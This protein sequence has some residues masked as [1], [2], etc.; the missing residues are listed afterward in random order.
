MM[1]MGMGS[2]WMMVLY[3]LLMLF[4]VLGFGYIIWVMASKESGNTKLAGQI[5]SV[6]IIVLAILLCLYG[7]VKGPGMRHK[8]M[9]QKMMMNQNMMNKDMAQP[10]GMDKHGMKMMKDHW[11]K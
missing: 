7:A 5:I 10:G 9:E 4:I 6:V 1:M 2:M 3:M 11:K 8:M